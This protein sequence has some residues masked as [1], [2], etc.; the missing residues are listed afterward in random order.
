M[1]DCWSRP[2]AAIRSFRGGAEWDRM[3]WNTGATGARLARARGAEAELGVPHP[4]SVQRASTRRG[5]GERSAPQLWDCVGTPR[6]LPPEVARYRRRYAGPLRLMHRQ[7]PTLRSRKQGR[8]R[9]RRVG[10]SDRRRGAPCHGVHSVLP[11]RVSRP[12]APA[13]RRVK[14]RPRTPAPCSPRP[15]PTP[16]GRGRRGRGRRPGL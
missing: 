4:A 14:A 10:G 8:F 2:S 6:P 3:A 5:R 12:V 16:L 13:S 15:S 1:A 7:S 11:S 9:H